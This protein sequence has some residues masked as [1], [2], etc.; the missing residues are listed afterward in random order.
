MW[1]FNKFIEN[2]LQWDRN[3]WDGVVKTPTVKRPPRATFFEKVR[4]IERKVEGPYE[5]RYLTEGQRRL[6]DKQERK[7]KG[8]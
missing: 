4:N 3:K 8:N 6:W 7:E 1:S 2:K 5:N